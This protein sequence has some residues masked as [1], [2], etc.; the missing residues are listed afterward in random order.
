MRYARPVPLTAEHDRSGFTCGR[1][2][3]DAWFRARALK[4][5]SSGAS[6][7]FVSTENQTGAVVGYYT[8]AASTVRTR[9]AP[10]AIRRKMPDPI[11]VIL[12]GR[13]AVDERH[14]S[15]GLGSAMLQDA[16]LRVARS[17]DIVGVRALLVHAIDDGAAG[18]YRAFGFGPSPLSGRVLFLSIAAIQAAVR[19]AAER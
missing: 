15:V 2:A 12:L 10:G 18:F 1:E 7:S 16:V 13:L 19:H 11:P 9:E 8:L 5:Q 4:N 3:L 6:R 17:A 14:Q